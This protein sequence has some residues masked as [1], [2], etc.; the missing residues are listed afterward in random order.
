MR[1][2]MLTSVPRVIYLKFYN[3]IHFKKY[4]FLLGFQDNCFFFYEIQS[5]HEV[6]KQVVR[7]YLTDET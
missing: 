6:P 4:N 1:I 3:V 5:Q 2:V 7:A